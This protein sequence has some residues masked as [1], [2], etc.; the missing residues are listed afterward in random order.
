ML[1]IIFANNQSFLSSSGVYIKSAPMF[2]LIAK[3]RKSPVLGCIK[4]YALQAAE[5]LSWILG[6]LA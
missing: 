5:N 6:Y 2:V 4:K 3:G 1:N